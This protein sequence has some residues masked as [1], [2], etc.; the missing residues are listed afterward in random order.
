M[1]FQKKVNIE[2]ITDEI[3]KSGIIT[4]LNYINSSEND[5]DILFNDELT[6]NELNILNSIVVNHVFT[7]IPSVT[8][9]QIRL[10]LLMLGITE[11]RIDEIINNLASGKEFTMITWKYSTMFERQNPLVPIIE[12]IMSFNSSEIDQLWLQAGL[13]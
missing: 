3:K 11:S 6:T 7:F 13:L 8:P 12:N 10:K 2:K 4:S 9:R 1:N 5:C